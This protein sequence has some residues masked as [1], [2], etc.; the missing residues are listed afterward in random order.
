MFYVHWDGLSPLSILYSFNNL[1][2][3]YRPAEL[4]FM[5]DILFFLVKIIKVKFHSPVSNKLLLQQLLMEK[6]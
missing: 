3:T 4:S 2:N 1:L 5:L 6:K